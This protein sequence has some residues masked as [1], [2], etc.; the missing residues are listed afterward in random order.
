MKYPRLFFGLFLLL[1][2]V[3]QASSFEYLTPAATS[4]FSYGGDFGYA[5]FTY[6]LPV[7]VNPQLQ[8]HNWMVKHG[9]IAAYNVT[10]NS[11]CFD[12]GDYEFQLRIATKGYNAPGDTQYSKPECYNGTSWNFIQGG[13]NNSGAESTS[14]IT[15]SD[16]SFAYDGDF[17][18]YVGYC[19]PC[20][21][22]SQI[23]TSYSTVY[24][25][26]LFV[27]APVSLGNVVITVRNQFGRVIEGASVSFY[28]QNN[29]TYINKTTDVAGQVVYELYQE[30][31]YNVSVTYPGSNSFTGV[32]I[33][34]SSQYG[35]TLFSSDVSQEFLNV[36]L[37]NIT[38]ITT[39]GNELNNGPVELSMY[40]TGSNFSYWGFSTTY[41][42]TVYLNNESTQTGG[43][44]SRF[45]D[46]TGGYG[47]SVKI[48]YFF[49]VQNKSEYERT[50]Y[51]FIGGY[52]PSDNSIAGQED[53]N[54]IGEFGKTLIVVSLVVLLFVTFASFGVPGEFTALFAA[55]IFIVGG[56]INWM[57]PTPA[58]ISATVM[59]GYLIV[60]WRGG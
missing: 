25:A 36:T 21:T 8:S 38:L 5:Y 43:N 16:F 47:D 52:V 42:G 14:T 6:D 13:T 50:Q 10:V 7:Y 40:L 46:L 4:S 30:M 58:Y 33:P 24:D 31:P 12:Y 45:I 39:P 19:K 9:K 56:I 22:K 41:N 60:S 49:K 27:Q 37:G 32:L 23:Y 55:I 51:Y 17:S 57:D 28:Y 29:G 54:G 44:T 2:P 35:F 34:V 26:K 53:F 11:T 20:S 1:L 15:T 59:V 48:D 18:T 3:A